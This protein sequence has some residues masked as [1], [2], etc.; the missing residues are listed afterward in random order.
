VGYLE[1]N[2]SIPGVIVDLCRTL[3]ADNPA[4]RPRTVESIFGSIQS[5]L[6]HVADDSQRVTTVEPQGDGHKR[7]VKKGA[8]EVLA[9]PPVAVSILAG[10]PVIAIEELSPLVVP[11]P[12]AE[13]VIQT[14]DRL[15]KRPTH[16][17]INKSPSA[18]RWSIAALSTQFS[19]LVI[20]GA[21]GGAAVFA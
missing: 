2:K 4:D 1:A 12:Q 13:L 20:A 16:S 17:A 3:M 9:A 11:P 5:A 10:R 14:R 8:A 19:P 7:D 6:S 15:G 18:S 21:I